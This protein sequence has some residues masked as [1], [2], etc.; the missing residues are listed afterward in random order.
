[1][2]NGGKIIKQTLQYDAEQDK[3]IELRTK[4]EEMDYRFFPDPDLPPLIL[5]KVYYHYLSIYLFI[6]LISLEFSEEFSYNFQQF[7]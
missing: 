7:F 2:E 6:L 5:S 3:T 4:Q 1:M